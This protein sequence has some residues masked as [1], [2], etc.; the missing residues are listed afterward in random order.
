MVEST[1][2]PVSMMNDLSDDEFRTRFRAFLAEHFPAELKQD[3]RRPFHRLRGQQSAQWQR[4]LLEYGWRAPAWP[5]KFGGMGLSFRKQLIYHEEL[6]VGRIA[7]ITDFGEVH[8]GPT[9]MLLGTDEQRA[10]YLPPILDC[11]HV[12]CQGYSEPSAGSDLASLRTH[13]R[14]DGDHLVV[15]GQKIWT[16]QASVSTHIF[17]LVRTGK[18]DKKQQGISFLLIELGTPGISV[19]PIVNLAGEDD[20]CEVFFDEV[21]VPLANVVGRIDDGWTVAK[22]VLGYERVF[23]GSPALSVR[24]LDLARDLVR[25]RGLQSDAGVC[26][27]LAQLCADL[28]DYQLLYVDICNKLA[29]SDRE[30]GPEVSVLKIVASELVQRITEFN[31]EVAAEWGGVV[32]DASISGTLTDLHWQFMMAR[33]ISIFAGANEVQRDIMAK[34]VLGLRS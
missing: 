2:H 28:H 24:A 22:A 7:R 15:N 33:P 23:T 14:I 32:G 19:R 18:F 31:L 1:T 26:D 12:W 29:E 21:R 17:A 27:R 3:H 16:T 34:S 11:R 6:A 4:T 9:L 5:R 25:S 30:P 20:L 8:L 13:A 10:K